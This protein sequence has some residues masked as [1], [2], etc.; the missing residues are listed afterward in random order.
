MYN[1]FADGVYGDTFF[2]TTS[3]FALCSTHQCRLTPRR[4]SREWLVVYSVTIMYIYFVK[5]TLYAIIEWDCDFNLFY[6]VLITV[7]TYTEFCDYL[8]FFCLK[9]NIFVIAY[10]NNLY[11][12]Y[13]IINNYLRGL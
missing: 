13:Y 3:F 8:I 6:Q 1:M 9:I 5:S 11:K 12:S 7:Y 4:S 10:Y 2:R